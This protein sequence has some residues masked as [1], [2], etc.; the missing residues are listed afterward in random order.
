GARGGVRRAYLG[1]SAA[2]SSVQTRPEPDALRLEAATSFFLEPEVISTW[3]GS[4]PVAGISLETTPTLAPAESLTAAPTLMLVASEARVSAAE[5]VR[6]VAPASG[7]SGAL[8]E[9]GGV[10]AG[11]G[12]VAGVSIGAGVLVAGGMAADGVA[13]VACAAAKAGAPIRR[14]EA[15]AA[16]QN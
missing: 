1:I 13:V 3:A 12:A 10:T 9:A 6:A 14:P 15:V 11:G 5:P 7:V 2:L 4:E 8:V 16:S